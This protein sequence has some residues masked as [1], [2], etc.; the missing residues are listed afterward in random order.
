MCVRVLNEEEEEEEERNSG[1]EREREREETEKDRVR[2]WGR[3]S[4]ESEGDVWV[5]VW[6]YNTT[7]HKT[8]RKFNELGGKIV[9]SHVR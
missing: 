5:C 3:E 4:R 9:N 2:E 7:L 6:S 8:T 1:R